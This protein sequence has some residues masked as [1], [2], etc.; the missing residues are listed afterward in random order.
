MITPNVPSPSGSTQTIASSYNQFSSFSNQPSSRYPMPPNILP[1]NPFPPYFLP[2]Q[3]P[4]LPPAYLSSHAYTLQQRN[5]PTRAHVSSEYPPPPPPNPVHLNQQDSVLPSH[6]N[7]SIL[8]Q[9]PS[10]SYEPLPL[11]PLTGGSPP[12]HRP[13]SQLFPL[14]SST[15]PNSVTTAAATA[16][17]H[18]SLNPPDDVHSLT[19]Q[20]SEMTTS[21]RTPNRAQSDSIILD[22][23]LALLITQ[24]SHPLKNLFLVIILDKTIFQFVTPPFLVTT[25]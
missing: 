6:T 21:S 4:V 8:H 5:D 13:S 24:S 23:H 19:S 7:T 12:H 20:F 2:V 9:N 22:T 17:S 3:Q 10:L 11:S 18:H 14:H 25:H 16:T 15:D 1:Y